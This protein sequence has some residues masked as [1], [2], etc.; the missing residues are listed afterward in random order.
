MRTAARH[1]L[2][3]KIGMWLERHGWMLDSTE[4]HGYSVTHY[5]V[6]PHDSTLFNQTYALIEQRRINKA[7][8]ASV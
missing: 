6:S 8:K 3:T 7:V 1:G 4:P 5:W 2:R